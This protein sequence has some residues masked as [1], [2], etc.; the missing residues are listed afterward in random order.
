MRDGSWIKIETGTLSSILTLGKPELIDPRD[1]FRYREHWRDLRA[2]MINGVWVEQFGRQRFVPGR[3]LFFGNLCYF[4]EWDEET[5][6]RV[7]GKPR[8]RDL[9]WHRFYYRLLMDGFSG[10]SNSK[11]TS[12]EKLKDKNFSLNRCPQYVKNAILTPSGSFKDYLDPMDAVFGLHDED[13]GYPLY[14]N[15]AKNI[16]ELGTRGGGKTYSKILGGFLYDLCFDGQKH[17]EPGKGVRNTRAVLEI[18]AGQEAKSMEALTKLEYAM[19][20][21]ALKN[22]LGVWGSPDDPKSNYTPIPFWKRMEGSL[23]ANNKKNPWINEYKVDVGEKG[24]PKW[25]DKGSRSVVYHTVYPATEQGGGQK[26][27]GGRRT[28]VLHEEKGLNARL[29]EAWGS[30]EGMIAGDGTKYASQE[31]IGTSGNLQLVQQARRIHEDPRQFG[32]LE[33]YN[34]EDPQKPGGFFLP[35]YMVDSNFKDQDGN[36]DVPAAKKHWELLHEEKMNNSSADVYISFAMN[37]PILRRHMWMQAMMNVLPSAEAEAREKELLQGDAYKRVARPMKLYY[38]AGA[39]SGVSYKPDINAV[40]FYSWPLEIERKTLDAVFMMYIEPNQLMVNG[41]IPE[42][43]IIIV[44]DPY[45]SDEWDKGGSLGVTHYIV[46]PK[47]IPLGFPGHKIAATYIGKHSEGLDEYNRTLLMG[48]KLYGRPPQ[49]IWYEANRGSDLRSMAIHMNCVDML[50][51]QPQFSDGKFIYEQDTKRTG[52]VVGN[53]LAKSWLL[54]RFKYYLLSDSTSDGMFKDEVQREKEQREKEERELQAQASDKELDKTRL[55][56]QTLDC[57]FTLRQIKNFN[58][59]GNFDA[60]SSMLGL[61][62]AIGEMA[63]HEQR[64]SP[65]KNR[66]LN[67]LSKHLIDMKHKN[68]Y[69]RSKFPQGSRK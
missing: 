59:T 22:D 8:V 23:A 41:K 17:Y 43:M 4:E 29:I 69:G 15:E 52:Y 67:M 20:Q 42:D 3:I 26:S 65:S 38:D 19:N 1:K 21:L 11:F 51:V 47:Y 16:S 55:I 63:H 35:A 60:V 24:N 14:H 7:E 6:S 25:I 5:K 64:K 54:T 44:H 61:S 39:K 18:T 66:A 57:I 27:A 49:G 37:N 9:E 36:T 56:I 34:D 28:Y 10:F 32:C 58:A 62:L 12:Y 50:C 48:A 68:Q 33:L 46:S 31:G 45:V 40:P 13:L 2:K 53:E 30:N